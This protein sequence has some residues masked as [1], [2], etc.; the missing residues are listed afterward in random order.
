MNVVVLIGRLTRDPELRYTAQGTA[1][2]N[3]GIAV[4]RN[5]GG[6][7]DN[8]QTADFF[9]VVCWNK[10]AEI[11]AQYMT[12]GRQVAV[13]GRLQ[14]RSYEYEGQRRTSVEIVAQTVR[15]LDRQ[16]NFS[17]SSPRDNM[18]SRDDF[19]HNTEFNDEDDDLPF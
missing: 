3:F 12:K 11:V 19:S 18:S 8:Q 14:S 4:D 13:Q 5:Y 17:G 2:T 16:D 15:F 1:V 6:S 10:L 9:N 7:D